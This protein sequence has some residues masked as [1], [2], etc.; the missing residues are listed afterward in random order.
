[1]YPGIAWI[2]SKSFADIGAATMNGLDPIKSIAYWLMGIGTYALIIS[3]IQTMCFE[4]VAYRATNALRLEWFQAL[5]RQDAAY[6]DVYDIGGLANTVGPASNKYRRGLGRKFGEGIQFTTTGVGG[7]AYALYAEWR[8]ALV[9]LSFC[10]V[11]AYFSIAVIQLNQ[12]KSVRAAA[13][14]STAGSIAYATVSGIQTILSLNACPKMIHHYQV[15]THEAFI[16]ATATLIQQGFV[17]GMMLGSFLIMYIILTL[18][19]CYQIYHDVA[20]TGCDPS[21]GVS[22]N[23][24]CTSAGPDVFGAMLG[25][26]FAA[27]G[28]GQVGTFLETFSTARCAC[29]QALTSIRRRPITVSTM[30][31]EDDGPEGQHHQHQQQQPYSNQ[32]EIIYHEEEDDDEKEN[33]GTK[34]SN[35][36]STVNSSGSESQSNSHGDVDDNMVGVGVGVGDRESH[37]HQGRRIKAILPPYEIDAMSKQGYV[38]PTSMSE[39][40][41]EAVPVVQVQGHI[42]FTDVTFHYPTRPLDQIVN[43]LSIDIKAGN[44]IAFVGPSGGGKSTI[45]T[46]TV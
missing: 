20:N 19:G 12:T 17:N 25:I 32:A 23:M 44:T 40:N 3:T 46:C 21:G 30:E 26:A 4:I 45:G 33:K 31:N 22:T 2:F 43:G 1:M 42:A 39:D 10:P 35:H 24:T 5:L 15:A 11:I 38:F 37:P 29:G 36:T 18:Y 16:S 28:I 6:F 27:Q 41:E 14:Y 34:N 7:V 13:A 9:V 8:V